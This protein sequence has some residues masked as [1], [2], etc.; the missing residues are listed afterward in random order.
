MGGA[1]VPR[2]DLLAAPDRPPFQPGPRLRPS[3]TRG[4]TRSR[5]GPRDAAGQAGRP[6]ASRTQAYVNPEAALHGPARPAFRPP[7]SDL[8]A[9][10]PRFSPS[11]NKPHPCGDRSA[12]VF[13]A[14]WMGRGERRTR[15]RRLRTRCRSVACIA[16][17]AAATLPIGRLHR[18]DP[19]SNV[20]DR[21]L[22]S[23]GPLQQRCRSVACIAGT[24]AATLP[25]GRL[26]RWDP[27]SNVADRFS[28]M[29]EAIGVDAA[30]PIG[31]LGGPMQ[32]CCSDLE[33]ARAAWQR[34]SRGRPL[35][36]PHARPNF[37]GA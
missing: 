17:T 1:I 18:W 21:S 9:C 3:R 4:G 28:K 23:L 10:A 27:C 16:G 35:R 12:A 8:Q 22:A 15:A 20:A 26:H 2:Q 37:E 14:P 24:P 11:A 19:C 33:A 34:I 13:T 36:V 30:V 32:R 25:I 7:R 29:R 5:P 31:T 6:G